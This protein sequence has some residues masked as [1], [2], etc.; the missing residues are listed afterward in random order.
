MKKLV[1]YTLVIII[2][3]II[4]P[5]LIVKSCSFVFI[6]QKNGQV[7]NKMMNQLK[8]ARMGKMEAIARGIIFIPKMSAVFIGQTTK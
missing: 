6:H 1:Y 3:T 4:L 8:K 2:V 7:I 5:G